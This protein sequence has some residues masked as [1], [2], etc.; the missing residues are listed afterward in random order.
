VVGYR[1]TIEAK[2]RLVG[3]GAR[4]RGEI[5]VRALCGELLRR[6]GPAHRSSW[7]L[8]CWA[9]ASEL[10]CRRRPSSA[11]RL[12]SFCFLKKKISKLFFTFSSQ[13]FSSHKFFVN[14]LQK[15]FEYSQRTFL[16]KCFT[17]VFVTNFFLRE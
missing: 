7:E 2:S 17:K 16:L 9:G 5:L 1:A 15:L 8:P 10:A 12:F 14:S 11:D 13:S 4:A 3:G 6:G